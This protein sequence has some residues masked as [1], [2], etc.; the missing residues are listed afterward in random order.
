MTK[1][2]WKPLS[3]VKKK[4]HYVNNF[5]S[6]QSWILW[7]RPLQ[8]IQTNTQVNTNLFPCTKES[9][10]RRLKVFIL[11]IEINESYM[12]QICFA[13]TARKTLQIPIL[14]LALNSNKDSDSFSNFRPKYIKLS[15]SLW[16]DFTNSKVKSAYLFC[17]FCGIISLHSAGTKLLLNLKILMAK[18]RISLMNQGRIIFFQ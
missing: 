12:L 3:L 1:W 8:Q 5:H 11:F 6:T 9:H 14:T 7:W 10:Y 18:K 17:L 2:W 4:R 15:R 13:K 16:T